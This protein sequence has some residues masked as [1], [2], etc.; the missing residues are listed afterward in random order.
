M[1]Q[2]WAGLFSYMGIIFSK[3]G[4]ILHGGSDEHNLSIEHEKSWV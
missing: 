1:I 4:E 3:Y 2:S